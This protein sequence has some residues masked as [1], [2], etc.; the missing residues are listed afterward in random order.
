MAS[1]LCTVSQL[2][3]SFS[4][5]RNAK[6][7]KKKQ[8]SFIEN[9]VF[10]TKTAFI[11][12]QLMQL[13]RYAP[14]SDSLSSNK[15]AVEARSMET[16]LPWIWIQAFSLSGSRT[17]QPIRIPANQD[18]DPKPWIYYLVL[19]SSCCKVRKEK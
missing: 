19:K 10:S 18:P 2:F 6:V 17:D 16:E 13:R 9:K 15:K 14:T 1:L 5:K 12:V 7:F 4:S 3:F 8:K 11:F